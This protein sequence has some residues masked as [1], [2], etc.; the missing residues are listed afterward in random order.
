MDYVDEGDKII[1]RLDP[2]DLVLESWSRLEKR[3]I[4]RT[5]FLQV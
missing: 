5:D 3:K 2:G 4:C 1:L